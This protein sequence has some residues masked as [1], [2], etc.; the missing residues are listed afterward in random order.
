MAVRCGEHKGV[1]V[2]AA[3]IAVGAIRI[4]VIDA[5]GNRLLGRKAEAEASERAERIAL[6]AHLRRQRGVDRLADHVEAL[7]IG[8]EVG[9]EEQA[10]AFEGVHP[11]VAEA[12]AAVIAERGAGAEIP[13]DVLA[14]DRS[15]EAAQ[16][17]E[18]LIVVKQ[19]DA[20]VAVVEDRKSTRLNSSHVATSYAVFCL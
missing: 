13:A 3:R 6:C 11:E 7:G 9:A 8:H 4:E 18:R 20:T 15:F 2:A 1:I 5:E 10:A 14:A 12:Y 19:V 16:V 17:H